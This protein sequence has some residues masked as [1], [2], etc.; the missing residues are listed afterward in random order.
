LYYIHSGSEEYIDQTISRECTARDLHRFGYVFNFIGEF[1][2]RLA[3]LVFFLLTSIQLPPSVLAGEGVSTSGSSGTGSTDAIT[4]GYSSIGNIGSAY[5]SDAASYARLI[6]DGD[7]SGNFGSTCASQNTQAFAEILYTLEL[8]S[9][10]N[11]S[12]TML[13][14]SETEH[15]IS[16]GWSDV[17]SLKMYANI[18][19]NE[20]TWTA[21]STTSTNNSHSPSS[22]EISLGDINPRTNGSIDVLVRVEHSGVWTSG[23]HAELYVYDFQTFV[24]TAPSINYAG[25]PFTFTK[26]T[27]I[28]TA[29]PTNSGGVATSW[30]ITSGSLPAGLSFSTSTGDITGTPTAATT[31]ASITVEASNSAGSDSTMISITVEDPALMDNDDDGIVNGEDGCR[32][33]ETGWTSNSSTDHDGDGCR[34][35]TEDVDDDNDGADDTNDSFPFNALEWADF[36]EDS[37]GDNADTDD[38]N[39]GVD[40]TNDSFPFNAFEWADFDEDSIGDNADTDDDDDGVDDVVDIFPY[41]GSEW[42]DNDNDSIGDNADPDDDNDGYSDVD[43]TQSGG[44]PNDGSIVPNDWDGDWISDLLDD[45]DDNDGINDEDDQCNRQIAKNWGER[46]ADNSYSP[47]KSRDWDLDGCRDS[48]E[49]DDDDND[50]RLDGEDS[51]PRGETSWNSLD[52]NL[53]FDGDG[54]K[55]DKPEDS[56]DDNDDWTDE[57]EGQCG[58]D[59]KNAASK[60]AD[61]DGD[62]ICDALDPMSDLSQ[63]DVVNQNENEETLCSY[64]EWY[65]KYLG[66]EPGISTVLG[67][68]SL[69]FGFWVY[70]KTQRNSDRL[71]EGSERFEK[72]ERRFDY[73]EDEV[74]DLEDMIQSTQKEL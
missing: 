65:C 7:Y 19:D 21:W 42:S 32:D 47:D 13:A 64:V 58:T 67:I 71:D 66:I 52:S 12:I 30:S 56:D 57:E 25:S 20:G 46:N 54:C 41:N 28:S 62:G 1:M 49:D 18:T 55:D 48:D 35:A 11:Q 73:I 36:D 39:D 6:A 24:V 72:G 16:T 17:T 10:S 15:D 33:G 3:I 22:S 50:E 45:D 63:D 38:D 31:T 34:D 53:D 40:D 27:A 61:S 9:M 4:N 23:C 37:I 51:C 2:R 69:V 74:E 14:Y 59:S 8:A 29:S 43:E 44:D 70:R 60:P 5:D 68:V 26:N